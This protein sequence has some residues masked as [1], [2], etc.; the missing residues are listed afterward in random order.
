MQEK[1]AVTRFLS[2]AVRIAGQ[3]ITTHPS[4][5]A[6]LG[7]AALASRSFLTLMLAPLLRLQTGKCENLG[8]DETALQFSGH[9]ITLAQISGSWGIVDTCRRR[10][11]QYLQ[12]LFAGMDRRWGPP[13]AEAW[14]GKGA[15]GRAGIITDTH[16]QTAQTMGLQGLSLA[17]LVLSPV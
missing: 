4:S 3:G 17:R 1:Q 10:P 9:R 8:S 16:A 7:P 15:A 11:L 6:L 5:C 2:R 12:L 14:R 13:F